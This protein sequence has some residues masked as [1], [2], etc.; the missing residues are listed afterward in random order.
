MEALGFE[1]QV[2]HISVGLYSSFCSCLGGSKHDPS[3][4]LIPVYNR[5]LQSD[6]SSSSPFLLTFSALF[7]SPWL[8]QHLWVT[9]VTSDLL[10]GL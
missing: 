8:T 2:F 10:H 1:L 9:V 4:V 7:P 5:A 6:L 3:A